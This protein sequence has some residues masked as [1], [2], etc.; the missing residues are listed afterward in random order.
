MNRQPVVEY[1][2]Q[3]HRYNVNRNDMYRHAGIPPP[4]NTTPNTLCI[5][6][7]YNREDPFVTVV[8]P[9]QHT[10]LRVSKEDFIAECNRLA[11]EHTR[12]EFVEPINQAL[13]N[14][15]AQDGMLNKHSKTHHDI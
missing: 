9:P 13:L 14:Q 2:R 5:L 10:R 6:R 11:G 1:F 8:L 15:A 7:E 4:D 3:G 12:F